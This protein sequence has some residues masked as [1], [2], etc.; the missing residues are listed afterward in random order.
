MC[1]INIAAMKY[2]ILAWAAI[3]IIALLVY[4]V[5]F[6]IKKDKEPRIGLLLVC[7]I[8]LFCALYPESTTHWFWR[9]VAALVMMIP[10]ALARYIV[11]KEYNSYAES[12]RLKRINQSNIVKAK[13]YNNR[14]TSMILKYGQ[15]TKSI[16]IY[17]YEFDH[18]IDVFEDRQIIKIGTDYLPFDSIKGHSILTE[19]EVRK[20]RQFFHGGVS[21]TTSGISY[22]GHSDYSQ[23]NVYSGNFNGKFN[24]E[25]SSEND[26][27]EENMTLCV[28][29]GDM[30]N[31][32][33]YFDLGKDKR[34]VK[35]VDEVLKIIEDR[36]KG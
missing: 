16:Q 3:F 2:I 31:P 36:Y 12:Q 11:H 14:R 21:G 6:K 1:S 35:E 22:G 19:T 34:T 28:S 8:I 29:T 7:A 30:S 9:L 13:D 4:F 15:P 5:E 32:V 18:D 33:I 23:W 20:G 24:G 17:E 26:H 27:I 10:V 25:I